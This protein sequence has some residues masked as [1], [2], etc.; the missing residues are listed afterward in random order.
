[1]KPSGYLFKVPFESRNLYE[2]WLF[3]GLLQLEAHRESYITETL[4]LKYK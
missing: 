2:H 1:M 3:W 4:Q